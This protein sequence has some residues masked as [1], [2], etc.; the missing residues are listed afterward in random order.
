MGSGHLIAIILI[1]HFVASMAIQRQAKTRSGLF[2]VSEGKNM[3]ICKVLF[4]HV[5]F[6]DFRLKKNRRT[7]T[8]MSPVMCPRKQ[9]TLD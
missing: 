1:T 2:G 3:W 6:I 8:E 5:V 4:S 9:T 7:Q